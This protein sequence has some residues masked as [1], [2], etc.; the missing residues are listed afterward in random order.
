[1]PDSPLLLQE[2]GSTTATTLPPECHRVPRARRGCCAAGKAPGISAGTPVLWAG[3]TSGAAGTVLWVTRHPPQSALQLCLLVTQSLNQTIPLL[4]EV[5]PLARLVRLI[6]QRLVQPRSLLESSQGRERAQ[7][8][9]RPVLLPTSKSA[10]PGA[11]APSPASKGC[12]ELNSRTKEESPI[13]QESL[14][15]P[16]HHSSQEAGS[17]SVL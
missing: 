2:R 12:E 5:H 9:A 8:R 14:S 3:S 15:V 7:V 6:S 10:L 11:A 17:C 4:L 1:M 13:N 16:F